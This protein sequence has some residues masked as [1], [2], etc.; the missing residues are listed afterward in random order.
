MNWFRTHSY[1]SALGVAGLLLI[2]GTFVVV[3][4]SSTATTSSQTIA[5]GGAGA[6]LNPSYTGTADSQ[7]PAG[8]MQQVQGGAPYTYVLPKPQPV[9]PDTQTPASDGFDF[10]AFISLLSASKGNSAG[11]SGSNTSVG[12]AYAFIPGGLVSTTTQGSMRTPLQDSLYTYGNDVG[13]FIQSFELSHPNESQVLSD[14]AQ[15]R[16][17][18]GKA[19]ALQTLGAALSGLG[20]SLLS[21]DNVPSQLVS[22][23]QAL[24]QS[25]V[26][27]GKR[28]ALVP[29]A[30][31][32]A[33]F[34]AAIQSYDTS[35][36]TFT[37][38]YVATANLFAAYGVTF[39][40]SDAGS[41]FTFTNASL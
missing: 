32:D 3:S 40:S 4:R 37:K 2:A 18:A 16:T 10:N 36:Q 8:I 6:A 17:D 39:S 5:W 15:D 20:E 9:N 26:D 23:H 19:A 22:A 14:Q 25:Y 21:M 27:I 28:L 38:N 33:D 29:Q 13:S 24:A 11:Q 30:A 12:N 1:T 34:I 35:V 31:R 7:A 41:V